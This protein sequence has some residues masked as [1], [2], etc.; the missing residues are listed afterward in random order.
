M[1][2]K[3]L[4]T[5]PGTQYSYHLA[6]QLERLGLLYQY[7]TGFTIANNGIISNIYKLLPHKY[8]RKLSTRIINI[9]ANKTGINPGLEIRSLLNLKKGESSES[10]FYKRNKAFQEAISDKTIKK[11]D[12]V[13]GFDT[14]SW[15]LAERCKKLNKR[16]ILDVSIGHPLSKEAVYNQLVKLYPE[17]QEQIQSKSDQLIAL[18]NK[19]IELADTIVVPSSFVRNTYIDNGINPDKIVVNPFGTNVATFT[20]VPHQNSNPCFLFFGGLTA[21]KGLPFLLKVWDMLVK[22]HPACTLILAGYGILPKDC[23]LSAGVKNIGLVLPADRQKLFNMADVFVFPSFF[24]GLAQVQIE[25]AACG[26]PIIGSTQSGAGDLVEE[27]KSGFI[28]APED[29]KALFNA[30]EYFIINPEKI[31]IMGTS[32]RE[33]ASNSFTWDAYGDRWANIINN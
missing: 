8:Q 23:T 4:L 7:Q 2:P 30:M 18:E 31:E 20:V 26:L 32:S 21:R 13:I 28:I 16:F 15:I 25:A 14:S 33:I 3:V 27:G 9:P 10:V 17:W 19:E 6:E 12:V 11:A 1:V 22:K 24:E 29:D 5:H